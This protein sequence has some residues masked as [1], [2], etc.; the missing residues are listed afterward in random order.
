MHVDQHGV[1]SI[2]VYFRPKIIG[3]QGFVYS[4]FQKCNPLAVKMSHRVLLV[5]FNNTIN[6]AN[7]INMCSGA[8]MDT[9][10]QDYELNSLNYFPTR[11]FTSMRT[12]LT[13]FNSFWAFK[14]RKLDRK[15]LLPFQHSLYAYHLALMAQFY[16]H[17]TTTL[18]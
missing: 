17:S 4:Q 18:F 8:H 9:S 13:K 14:W 7:T 2:I 10:Y 12:E 5:R 15:H 11:A 6:R 3:K 1:W 16:E